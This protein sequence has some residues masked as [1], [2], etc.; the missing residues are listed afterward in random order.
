[1]PICHGDEV[2]PDWCERSTLL[3]GVA[4]HRL[5]SRPGCDDVLPH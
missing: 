2:L 4:K 1:M 3:T 5:A